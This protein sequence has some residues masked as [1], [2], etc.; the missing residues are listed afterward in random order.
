MPGPRPLPLP[1]ALAYVTAPTFA[2]GSN[3]GSMKARFENMAKQKED[4][5]RK[6]AEEERLR[7]QAKEKQEQ[8]EAQRK[9]EESAPAPSPTPPAQLSAAPTYQV[10]GGGGRPSRGSGSGTSPVCLHRRQNSRTMP[11]RTE[12]SC[13]RGRSLPQSRRI[14]TWLLM[15]PQQQVRLHSDL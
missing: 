15:R 1:P 8:E 2:A 7:R 4:E 14:C 9:M 10:S 6:R 5:D 13:T 3:T 12:S 11:R